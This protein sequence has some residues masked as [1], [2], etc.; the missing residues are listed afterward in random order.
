MPDHDEIPE[1]FSG[2]YEEA[3]RLADSPELYGAFADLARDP[4]RFAR[5]VEMG[6][7]AARELGFDA[8]ETLAVTFFQGKPNPLEWEP[9][10]I[11]LTR[12]RTFK[13]RSGTGI[14]EATICL[15][16]SITPTP[17]NPIA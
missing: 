1:E 7:D 9:F 11:T 6:P 2:A 13:K 3:V 15:G 4:D 16:I 10:R 12:C 5:A 14:Q 8:P 17:T